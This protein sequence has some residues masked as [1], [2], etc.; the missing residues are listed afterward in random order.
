MSGG[1]FGYGILGEYPSATRFNRAKL[2]MIFFMPTPSKS[3]ASR[4]SLPMGVTERMRPFP[5]VL[6]CTVSPSFQEPADTVCGEEAAGILLPPGRA[7]GAAAFFLPPSK[8]PR[9]AGA[10]AES[11]GEAPYC[12]L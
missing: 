2:A 4:Q 3:M 5:K 6:C 1:F 11:A 9:Q 8:P 10:A 7:A 12:T